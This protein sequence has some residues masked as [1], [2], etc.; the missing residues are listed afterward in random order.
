MNNQDSINATKKIIFGLIVF[1]GL[2]AMK[3]VFAEELIRTFRA[4]I[5]LDRAGNLQVVETIDY[6]F[7]ATAR[8]GIL[9]EIPF[10]Y[11]TGRGNYGLR[12]SNIFVS[13]EDGKRIPFSQGRTAG[14]LKLKIGDENQA[15]SGL[16]RY[17]ISYRVGR[18]INFFD[19][20][21][22]LYWN[23]TGNGW[24]V[25]IES[26]AATVS[27][28]AS[29]DLA[30]LSTACFAGLSGSRVSCNNILFP[31]LAEVKS[32]G[33]VA[34]VEF[35]Q[36]GLA[37][38]E[39]LSVVVGL[40][41]GLINQPT[42]LT[43]VKDFLLD[44]YYVI[45]PL[46]ALVIMFYLWRTRGRDPEG[47]KVIIAQ[48]DAPDKLTPAEVGT[49]ID[50]QADS[51]DISAEIIHLA[52][53]G[54]LKI[55]QVKASGLFSNSD[56][57]LLSKLKDQ[58]DLRQ[59]FDRY[60]MTAIFKGKT[61]VMLSE[62]KKTFYKDLAKIRA[63][64]YDAV[65]LNGYFISNPDRVRRFFQVIAG[66]IMV[67]TTFFYK[68]LGYPNAAGLSLTAVIVALFG[69]RMPARTI[70]GVVAREQILGLK[71]YLRVA[72][73]DRLDFTDAPDKNP[74]VFEKLLP[75]AIALKVEKEWAAQFAGIYENNNPGW[76]DSYGHTAFNALILTDSLKSFTAK[77]NA[78]LGA[79]AAGHQ[80][81]FGGGG[82]SGGGFGGGGGGSW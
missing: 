5:S 49:I 31:D 47:R 59:D 8:H 26:V 39:G 57:Y 76:Y 44:N 65:T 14:T 62:L 68:S 30:E 9:R 73:K 12:L 20:R 22:E 18:A 46:F 41:K 69:W 79:S 37:A 81:G 82:F 36:N 45:L 24:P 21:D 6:D 23:V 53:L 67:F 19:N 11:Q 2:L 25:A 35:R 16:N 13:G 1:G 61:E 72:E 66:L 71:E 7:G 27:F 75:Y 43:A 58:A 51:L 28:P 29:F 74:A 50:E 56:D 54:Y 10:G 40:P 78:V 42:S 4:A 48:Y 33:K 63:M 17:L 52:V 70:K 15:V 32:T 55:S 34:Q 60:L 77:T 64:I 3:P 80:S 38:G